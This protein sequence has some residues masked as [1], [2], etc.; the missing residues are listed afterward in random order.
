MLS[1]RPSSPCPSDP[2]S[3]AITDV[4]IHDAIP[5]VIMPA[6]LGDLL[7]GLGADDLDDFGELDEVDIE[8]DSEDKDSQ[9][10]HSH[11]DDQP[12]PL[13]SLSSTGFATARGKLLAPP[14]AEALKKAKSIWEDEEAI[15]AQSH[16][17]GRQSPPNKRPR[18]DD[19]VDL[20]SM[21]SFTTGRGVAVPP[22]SKQATERAAKLFE[23]IENNLTVPASPILPS[24]PSPSVSGF[25]L[26]SGKAIAPPSKASMAR[27]LSLFADIDKDQTSSEPPSTPNIATSAFRTGSGK[28]ATQPSTSS[29][30]RALSLFADIDKD[31]PSRPITSQQFATPSQNPASFVHP[32]TPSRTPLATTT[33]TFSSIKKPI[34]LKTPSTSLRR[35]GLGA[36]PTQ[37]KTVKRGFITPFKQVAVR[38]DPGPSKPKIAYQAV[39]DLDPPPNRISYR[40]S[41]FHPQYYTPADL[42]ELGIPE[43][44]WTM[45][46]NNAKYYQFLAEDGSILGTHQALIRLQGERCLSATAKWVDNHWTHILWKLAGEIQAK[47]D[48]FRSKWSWEEVMSQLIYRYEREFGAAQRPI[49]RRVQEH[50]SSPSLPMVLI[51]WAIHHTVDDEKGQT[52]TYL[53]LSDGWYRIRAQIDE[54]LSRAIAKGKIKVGRKLALTGAKLESGADGADVLEAFNSSHLMITGNSTALARWDRKL[55]LQ[56]EPFIASLSSLSVDGGTVTLMDIV[57]DNIFPLMFTNGDRSVRESPWDEDEE[58]IR[59]DKWKEQYDAE[60]NR[61]EDKM[62]RDLEKL[63]DVAGALA[64]YAEEVSGVNSEPP[65]TLDTDLDELLEARDLSNRVRTLSPDHIVHLARYAAQRMGQEMSDQHS[66]IEAELQVLCPSR[67]VRDLRVVRFHDA[68]QGTKESFRLGSLN[69]WDAKAMGSTSLQE[70][71]RYLVSNLVPGRTGD[72]GRPRSINDKATILLHTRRDTRWQAVE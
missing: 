52:R 3:P 66:E 41:H 72:W 38:Q 12:F 33:N 55:G 17:S 69:L 60:R 49:L 31:T 11:A 67:N 56:A 4:G 71:K 39:F 13:G 16:S 45:T 15:D 43:A 37:R 23:D 21:A 25:Q 58:R 18:L 27:A 62:R 34:I 48:L 36:T 70:G 8:D 53:E 1:A 6:D 64:Q 54:C 26:G 59:Q 14:S 29:M 61:L 40:A 24:V 2:D 63:E 35:I 22:P 65:E 5:D 32:S 46:S 51:V 68:Q 57:V 50:D 44:I 7:S 20:S 47:P 42:T 10:H 30:S 28:L 9:A 19:P